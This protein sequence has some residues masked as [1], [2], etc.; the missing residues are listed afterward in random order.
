MNYEQLALLC[1]DAL[2]L[3]SLEHGWDLATA[4][5]LRTAMLNQDAST[6]PE[7]VTSLDI[8]N[9]LAPSMFASDNN[10]NCVESFEAV[11]LDALDEI[12]KAMKGG[13]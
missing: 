2:H 5:M 11:S 7:S 13:V 10:H 9:A 3:V 4:D 8:Y 6:I 12:I 1:Y